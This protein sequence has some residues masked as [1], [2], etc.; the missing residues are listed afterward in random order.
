MQYFETFRLS[1]HPNLLFSRFCKPTGT[2]GNNDTSSWLSNKYIEKLLFI[3]WFLRPKLKRMPI[4]YKKILKYYG[5]ADCILAWCACSASAALSVLCF[6]N[7]RFIACVQMQKRWRA[8]GASMTAKSPGRGRREAVR[9]VFCCKPVCDNNLF[10]AYFPFGHRSIDVPYCSVRITQP[11]CSVLQESRNL[12][13]QG[14][15][16]TANSPTQNSNIER[17]PR[18]SMIRR[19]F[20][21]E[22]TTSKA[23]ERDTNI[24]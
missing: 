24:C 2:T 10:D 20:A 8:N 19:Y 12:F 3:R 17:P 14:N 13:S 18:L 15:K 4:I 5:T 23:V 21:S 1:Q 11:I 9:A 22:K 16:R 7:E 6:F